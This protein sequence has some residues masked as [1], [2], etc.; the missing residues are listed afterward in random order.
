MIE[1]PKPL[2]PDE[3]Y[4][5]TFDAWN[6]LVKL[7]DDENSNATV[8]EYEWNGLG[9]GRSFYHYQRVAN[10]RTEVWGVQTT[11]SVCPGRRGPRHGT[12][13]RTLAADRTLLCTAYRG[14]AIKPMESCRPAA[15]HRFLNEY[16]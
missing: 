3:G 13:V 11:A 15:R 16:Y 12:L 1:M 8:A 14:A 7:T 4:T 5:A 10:W 2:A 9:S 6:R